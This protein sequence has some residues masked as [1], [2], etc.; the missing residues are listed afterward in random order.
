[1]ALRLSALRAGRPLPQEDPWYP[2]RDMRSES[3]VAY[4]ALTLIL[5]ELKEANFA[6]VIKI[7]HS[8]QPRREKAFVEISECLII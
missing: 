1:M 3:V 5:S 6:V 8:A 2:F 4:A 7:E